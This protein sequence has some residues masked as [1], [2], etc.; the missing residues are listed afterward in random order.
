MTPPCVTT[1]ASPAR[2]IRSRL[3]STR[4]FSAG[5]A[6]AARE[7]DARGRLHPRAEQRRLAGGNLVVHASLELA[8][9]ELAQ[10][11][12][13]PGGRGQRRRGLARAEARARPHGTAVLEARRQLARVPDPPSQAL[14]Q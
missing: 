5:P 1:T 4:A 8:E 12:V 6:L 14:A 11:I 13:D 10:V 9:V 7:L 3:R 2:S